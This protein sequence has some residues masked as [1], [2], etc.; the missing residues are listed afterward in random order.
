MMTAKEWLSRAWDI[1]ARIE[2]RIEEAA[3]LRAKLTGRTAHL[4]GM[5]RGGGTDWTEAALKLVQC[6]EQ[7]NADIVR[8][9][10]VKRE[11]W[12]AIEAV[13]DLKCRALLE[14][15]YRNYM[16]WGQ[17]REAMGYEDV[18]TVYYLH[19]RALLRVK[20]PA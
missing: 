6:E 8:L 3:R 16:T 7:I 12:D 19:G 5:P 18:R 10:A 9:C 1:D 17:I 15:R 2:R 14:M 4:T 11:V 20:F 13:E